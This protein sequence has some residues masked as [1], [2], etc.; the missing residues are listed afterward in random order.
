MARSDADIVR[1]ALERGGELNQMDMTRATTSRARQL[2]GQILELA[3]REGI[4]PG[5]RMFEHRLAQRLGISRG[6]VRAGLKELAHAGLAAAVPNRGYVLTRS[7][8]SPEARQIV[9]AA[10]AGDEHYMKIAN[11]RFDGRLPD[12]VSES[13]LMR[14]YGLKRPDL[15][16][17][18]DRIAAE[19]WVER[20]PGYG[21]RFAQ[22]LSSPDAYEQT[23]RFR[24]MIEP[25]G[26]LEP[27]FRLEPEAVVRIREQQE[28][29]LNGGLKTFTPAE[30]FRFG[31][32]FHETIAQASGNPFLVDALR[33]INSVRRLFAYRSVIPDHAVI[34]RQAREHVELLDLLSRG[35]REEASRY[36]AWHLQDG[37]GERGQRSSGKIQAYEFV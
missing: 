12:V 16:R 34:E 23:A 32:E 9:E 1:V 6:P 18:L 10:A 29:V 7:L 22:T 20:S 33:R 28:R 35:R 15:L 11:D 27:A 4:K 17:L 14:R 19:G 3:R 31:C 30:V 37:L 21:W 13:E 2:A 8:D 5:E 26:I 24:M 36:M 25:A